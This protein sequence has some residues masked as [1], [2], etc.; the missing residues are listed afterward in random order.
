M[1]VKFFLLIGLAAMAVDVLADEK[2]PVLKVGGETFSNVMVTKVSATDIYFISS[3]GLRNAKL[4]DLDPQLQKHF[5]SEAPKAHALSAAVN[6]RYHF[7][8]GSPTNMPVS[9]AD[10]KTELGDAMARVREIV[11]RPVASHA[12]TADMDVAVYS[13]GWFH[14]GALRPDFNTV[15]V[16]ASQELTYG[17]HQWVSSDLNPDVAFVGSELEFNSMTKYFYT[18]RSVPKRR[19]TEDEMQE[20]NRLYRIIGNDEKRLTR[21]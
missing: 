15:D 16:R 19:L 13:P 1:S 2:L 11:N 8:V 3:Q 6:S 7:R 5:L 10:V 20:I 9:A 12:R 14:E 17:G 4:K 21:P 18:D